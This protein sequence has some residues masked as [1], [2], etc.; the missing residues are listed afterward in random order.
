MDDKEKLVDSFKD[1]DD[2]EFEIL[3]IDSVYKKLKSVLDKHDARTAT[4][5]FI[6]YSV[7][8][9][10]KKFKSLAADS[11]RSVP[12]EDAVDL[13]ISKSEGFLSDVANNEEK[14][15]YA[16]QSLFSVFELVKSLLFMLKSELVNNP[17]YAH[18]KPDLGWIW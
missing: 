11:N 16:Y 15:P 2:L 12:H 4:L 9:T 14:A 13:I 10:V 8:E 3:F 5:L 1:L 7:V 6:Y 18:L 17:K